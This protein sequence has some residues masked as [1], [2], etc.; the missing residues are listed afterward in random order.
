VTLSPLPLDRRRFGS[1]M[2]AVLDHADP[3][4]VDVVAPA[5]VKEIL[6]ER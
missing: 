5:K 4:N 6:D 3:E 2:E 1:H